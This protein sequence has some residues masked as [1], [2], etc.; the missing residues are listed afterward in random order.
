MHD[1]TTIMATV[2]Q[3]SAAVSALLLVFQGY[4]WSALSNLPTETMPRVKQRYKSGMAYALAALILSVLV[5][6][7][8]TA[9]LVG[10]DLFWFTIGGFTLS[11]LSVVA[12]SVV[13]TIAA[14]GK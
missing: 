2:L 1:Q 13:V 4:Y 6:L 8:A 10:V 14:L 11:L 7:G 9:W 5:A 12:L 3:V